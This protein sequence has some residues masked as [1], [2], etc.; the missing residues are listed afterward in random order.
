MS[1]VQNPFDQM[2]PAGGAS[3]G[4]GAK[5]KRL[6][7]GRYNAMVV[8]V[9]YQVTKNTKQ[10]CIGVNFMIMPGSYDSDFIGQTIN[11]QMFLTSKSLGITVANIMAMRFDLEK[12]GF[13][14]SK[15]DDLVGNWCSLVVEINEGGYPEVK[16]INKLG[17]DLREADPMPK[18]CIEFLQRNDHRATVKQ[19]MIDELN[20]QAER[21]SKFN[22]GGP[23]AP[24]NLPYVGDP[25][26]VAADAFGLPGPD[27]AAPALGQGEPA[28]VGDD[29]I[30]FLDATGAPVAFVKTG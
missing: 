11:R 23:P 15:L 29:D 7:A 5:R 19:R 8:Q 1:D 3:S 12:V 10:P 24:R 4:S 22:N 14:L 18:E 17:F 13:D 6:T 27:A 20:N 2:A 28:A 26:T 9:A 30:P 25:K 16:F 21:Q